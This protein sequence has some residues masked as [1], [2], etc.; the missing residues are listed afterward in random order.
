MT[1]VNV[2]LNFSIK[3]KN[4]R[5]KTKKKIIIIDPRKCKRKLK[6]EYTQ[7]L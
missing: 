2:Y 4:S 1:Y 5:L 3:N 6:D 7:L